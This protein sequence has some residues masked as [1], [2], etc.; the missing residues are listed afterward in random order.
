MPPADLTQLE[1]DLSAALQTVIADEATLQAAIDAVK[2]ALP[3][4]NPVADAD[5]ACV[6]AC[7][8]ALAARDAAL[9]PAV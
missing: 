5:A 7:R 2:S 9:A 1:A 3:A 4:P 6:E 8:A